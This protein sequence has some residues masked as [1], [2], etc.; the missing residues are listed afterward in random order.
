MIATTMLLGAGLIGGAAPAAG[1]CGQNSC[2]VYTQTQTGS[3]ETPQDVV[4]ILLKYKE[5]PAIQESL[6]RIGA[7]AAAGIQPAVTI[8][9]SHYA[10]GSYTWSGPTACATGDA[11]LV[12]ENQFSHSYCLSDGI[13]IPESPVAPAEKDPCS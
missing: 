8:T 13:C 7:Y 3:A 10:L 4:K 12:L 6:R 5:T 9:A 2:W 1:P 11:R